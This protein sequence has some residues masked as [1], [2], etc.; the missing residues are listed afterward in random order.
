MRSGKTVFACVA[1]RLAMHF[2]KKAHYVR[3]CEL[4]PW[5]RKEWSPQ[6]NA[7]VTL[8]ERFTTADLVVIDDLGLEL[9]ETFATVRQLEY[10]LRRR[11]EN[12]KGTIV[13][14]NRVKRELVSMYSQSFKSVLD[15]ACPKILVVDTPQ[16]RGE[17]SEY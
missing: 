1:L 9:Q 4:S 16:W 15:R 2:G 3:A 8:E 6:Y 10:G 12:G 7:G 13:I 11:Y 14:T 17:C 5:W